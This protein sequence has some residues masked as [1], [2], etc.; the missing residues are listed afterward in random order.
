MLLK[1]IELNLYSD[2]SSIEE[3]VDISTLKER[4]VQVV[5][6]IVLKARK[7]KKNQAINRNQSK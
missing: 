3:Y 7:D 6:R 1:H 4:M 2:A 5:K